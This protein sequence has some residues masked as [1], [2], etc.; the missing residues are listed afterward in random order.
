MHSSNSNSSNASSPDERAVGESTSK[1]EHRL[2]ST[3]D[4]SLLKTLLGEKQSIEEIAKTLNRSQKSVRR[5]CETSG[6]S[7]ATVYNVAPK[8]PESQSNG[9]G[10]NTNQ[11]TVSEPGSKHT[12]PTE[13]TSA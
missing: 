1:K 2:W 7:S 12:A 11:N 6:M 5:K 4:T 10:T 9:Q 8:A 3:E 13:E